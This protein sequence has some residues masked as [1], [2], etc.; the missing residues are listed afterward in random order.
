M[1]NNTLKQSVDTLEQYVANQSGNQETF[2]SR[3]LRFVSI[4][5]FA[6]TTTLIGYGIPE[7]LT[8]NARRLD[9]RLEQSLRQYGDQNN[10]GSVSRTERDEFQINFS[11]EYGLTYVS[12]FSYRYSD[13]REVPNEDLIR[14]LGDYTGR[15][16]KQRIQ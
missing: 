7:L 5:G 4:I 15:L 16:S 8:T 11:R 14:M 6:T 3:M 10:D 13:G 2:F 9:S 12:G 1:S